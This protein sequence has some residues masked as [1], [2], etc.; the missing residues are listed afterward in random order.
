MAGP[1]LRH[2]AAVLAALA[3]AP[4]GAGALLVQPHWRHGLG[5]RLGLRSPR[6]PGAVWVHGASVGEILAATRL[7]D[8]L[9]ERGRPVVASTA[10]ATGRAVLARVRPDVPCTLAPLDHPWCVAAALGRVAPSG[11][12]LVE[13][14]LWPCWIGAA[15]RRGMPVAVVS[16]RISER[17]FARFRRLGRL[18]RG[19]FTSLAAVGARS[20]VDA[21]RFA[22]L[23]VPSERISVTGDLKLEPPNALPALALDLVRLLGSTPFWVAASTRPGEEEAAVAAHEMAQQAVL[24]SA[25]VIAP[26]HLARL[27]EI[28]LLLVAR[29]V[30]VRRR[31]RAGDRPLAPGEVLLL[32]TIGELPSVIA[33]ARFA[34][35]GGTL[36]PIGG[37]NVLE[38]AYAGRG[39]LF[40]PH[41]DK[42]REATQLLLASGGARS[43]A[44][45]GEL[46]LAVLDWLRDER[47]ADARGAA[48]LR[49]L[50][51]HRGATERSVVL[52]ERLLVGVAA[53]T[54]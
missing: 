32:D 43:V 35:V 14:E 15:R 10:T 12:V 48:A 21:E 26:R 19:T 28:E 53:G 3:A 8:A 50:D 13:A 1:V 16:A 40:G 36:A 44:H 51:R 31:S 11:L 27:E 34:F 42:V 7:L 23:G 49:E 47:E 30:P 25:L 54:G 41:V 38:P 20:E 37:H 4:I 6:A 9:R 24:P 22:A 17:S 33:R 45:A 18:V 29:G 46:A 52:V 39:V 5:E 2:G